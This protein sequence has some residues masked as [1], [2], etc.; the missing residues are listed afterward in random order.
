MWIPGGSAHDV[1][2][3]PPVDSFARRIPVTFAQIQKNFRPLVSRLLFF[4]IEVNTL[5]V[6]YISRENSHDSL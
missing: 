3:V 2:D 4:K 5:I 6:E 1:D